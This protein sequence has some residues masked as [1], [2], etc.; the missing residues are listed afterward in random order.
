[1]LRHLLATLALTA[2]ALCSF[3][4]P[5]LTGSPAS[6]EQMRF[7]PSGSSVVSDGS[8]GWNVTIRMQDDN[9]NSSLG[10]TFR[11]WWHAQISNLNSTTGESLSV[12]ITNT[13]Y[14][15]TILP[16]WA[17]STDGGATFGDYERVPP[18]AQIST[19]HFD[20]QTPVGVTDIRLAKYFPYTISMRD[21]FLAN[22]VSNPHVTQSVI[23]SSE[24]NRPIY[25]LE[26]TNSSVPDSLKHR[27][28]IHTCVHPAETTAYYTTEGLLN[29]LTSGDPLA[30][31]LLDNV[32]LDIVPMANPDGVF[33]GNYRTNSN[34]VNLEVQWAPPYNATAAESVALRTKIEEFMGTSAS[35]GSNPIELLLNLHSSHGSGAPFHYAHYPNYNVN[36]TGVIPEVRAL[37]DSWIAAFQ[38]RSPLVG[39]YNQSSLSG[40]VYVESMMHDR[41]SIDSAWVGAPNNL[42]RVMAITY[43]GTYIHDDT[44][45]RQNGWE[46]GEAIADYF[47]IVAPTVPCGLTLLGGE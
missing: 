34:S 8:G 36:G 3:A 12:T 46:M 28:W 27:V 38:A 22:I 37:E 16:V 41:W 21:E 6:G 35:P 42:P 32:I 24:Q 31:A 30:Q 45:Y 13:G 18:A 33:L 17:F 14:T 39:G 44:D 20:L 29:F 10:S 43:E 5:I 9:E 23:G 25:L 47:G 2:V 11:R 26:V 40:R 1:M 19:Y 15:D 7:D 4:Q